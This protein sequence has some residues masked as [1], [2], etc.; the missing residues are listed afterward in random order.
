MKQRSTPKGCFWS[1]GKSYKKYIFEGEVAEF[2][3][4]ELHFR[5]TTINIILGFFKFRF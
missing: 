5:Y 2:K 4:N 1:L 3:L